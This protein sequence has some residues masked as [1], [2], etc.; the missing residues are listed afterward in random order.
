MNRDFFGVHCLRKVGSVTISL[1]FRSTHFFLHAGLGQE[2]K[3]CAGGKKSK[4]R[5]TIAFIVNAA[6]G[7]ESKPIVIAKSRNPRC[8][9]HVD[10][11]KLPVQ[12]YHQPKSWMTGEILDQILGK[13]KSKLKSASRSVLLTCS[14]IVPAVILRI[15]TTAISRSYFYQ[16]TQLQIFNL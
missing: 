11:S 8:F 5:I 9:K 14:W 15:Y 1:V 16:P 12:Y 6:G 3:N 13:L 2:A 7:S 4:H 10:K